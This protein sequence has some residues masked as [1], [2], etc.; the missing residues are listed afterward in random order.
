MIFFGAYQQ[1]FVSNINYV[2][3]SGG[4]WRTRTTQVYLW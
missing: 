2:K 3:W 1:S 4:T